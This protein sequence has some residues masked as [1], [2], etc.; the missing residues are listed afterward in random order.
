M[1]QCEILACDGRQTVTKTGRDMGSQ[2]GLLDRE[3]LPS[4]GYMT[5]TASEQCDLDCCRSSRAS[6]AMLMT[7]PL[8]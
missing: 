2:Q 5:S 4:A 3:I 1:Q 6:E 8:E 7:M